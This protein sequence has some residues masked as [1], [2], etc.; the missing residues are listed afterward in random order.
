MKNILLL[1]AGRSSISLIKYLLAEKE[2]NNFKITISDF[3]LE[4]PFNTIF[5]QLKA[6][7]LRADLSNENEIANLV[8]EADLVISLLPPAMH[9]AVVKQCI[10]FA[11]HFI[12]ASYVSDEI[13]E[14]QQQA[15]AKGIVIGFI[16][17]TNGIARHGFCVFN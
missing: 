16:S 8:K 5:P 2:S 10:I 7:Y 15:V 3:A 4:F 13:K 9:L 17:R 14:L 12:S 6:K 11:K 1:G